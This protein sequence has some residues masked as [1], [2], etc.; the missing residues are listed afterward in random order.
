M[1]MYK[2][3]SSATTTDLISKGG[4]QGGQILQIS[5]CNIDSL[6]A[7]NV[8]VFLEDAAASETTD[9][10]NNKYYFIKDIDI[11][12]GATLVLDKNLSFNSSLYNLRITTNAD[13]SG[14]TPSLSII[15]K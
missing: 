14:G 4:D 9:A 10:S 2:N 7:E 6:A 8:S 13:G 5:I 11:P 12:V 3:I 1:A 15:I